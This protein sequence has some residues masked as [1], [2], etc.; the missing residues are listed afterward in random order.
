MN[1]LALM[2]LCGVLLACNSM[3]SGNA[4]D[5]A[6]ALAGAHRSPE[7]RA[8]DVHRHPAETLAFFGFKPDLTVVEI[9]PGGGWYT[10]ILAPALRE[11][12]KYIAATYGPTAER[13]YQQRSYHALVKRFE[14]APELYGKPEIVLFDPPA[15][16]E[17]GAPGSVDQVLTFRNTH[18]WI[19]AG[20][21]EQVFAAFHRALK[22]GGTLGVVQHRAPAGVD[23][24]ESAKRG[25]VAQDYIIELVEAAGFEL[26]ASSEINANP[27]DTKD[28]PDGV[29]NLPPVFMK[30]DENRA[31]YA[32]IG[33][34][35]RMTLRFVKR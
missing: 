11:Q 3:T 31:H 13:E 14:A 21:A 30:K 17:L 5:I 4:A 19:R 24:I 29:W 26:V 1:R 33:E 25:Y 8:R 28:H 6:S 34:S 22:P 27:K 12:G 7:S 15:T 20:V 9:L 16:L 35:D 23:P 32:A 2:T 10:E 18:N